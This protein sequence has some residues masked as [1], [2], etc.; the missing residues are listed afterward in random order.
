M[1]S[2]SICLHLV[3]NRALCHTEGV[4]PCLQP[5]APAWTPNEPPGWA[6][7]VPCLPPTLAYDEAPGP[8]CISHL[9][10]R[11]VC[12]CPRLELKGDRMEQRSFSPPLFWTLDFYECGRNGCKQL[13][14]EWV[15]GTNWAIELYYH[16]WRESYEW[17]MLSVLGGSKTNLSWEVRGGHVPESSSSSQGISLKGRAVSAG[18]DVASDPRYGTTCLFQAS[19]FLLYFFKSIRSE[20]W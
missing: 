18:N 12:Q 7:P 5:P 20:V 19:G 15:S 1:K 8:L 10:P 13:V 17:N 4:F 11:S 9:V 6:G 16:H 14:I 3:L 2:Y